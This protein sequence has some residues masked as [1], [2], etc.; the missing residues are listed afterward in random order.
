MIET[1]LGICALIAVVIFC[2]GIRIIR[3][4]ERGLVETFGKY[5]R[6]AEPGFNWILVGVQ[7][8]IPV[9]ITEIM[10]DIPKQMVITKDKLNAEVDAVVYYKV[11]N[12]KASQY[13]VNNHKRQL[14]SLARTTLR[15]VMGKMSLAAANEN[16]HQINSNVETVLTAETKSYGVEVLRV[17]I[18]SID[19]PAD[20]QD[21]MNEVVKA[22]QAKISAQDLATAT[23]TKADGERRAEIKKAEGIKQG[24]ILQA[25][26]KAEAI[27]LENEAAEKYFIGNAQLLKKLEVTV[28]SLKDNTKIVIPSESELVNVIGDLSGVLPLKR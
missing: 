21:A 7:Q 12:I 26:G 15:A 9:N 23:E 11:D 24:R 28:D 25:E 3:P 10:V 18:Q 13:N 20:V 4:V 6:I 19:P 8:I 1:I 2:A 22:E 14:A 5:T 16:R 27:K 17:E